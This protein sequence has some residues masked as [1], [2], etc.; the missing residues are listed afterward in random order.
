M[1][2]RK[3]IANGLRL[4]KPRSVSIKL[5]PEVYAWLADESD[6]M[7]C[8]LEVLVRGLIEDAYDSHKKPSG[9]DQK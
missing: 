1:L 2:D 4:D 3:L 6:S 8:A 9:G 5:R 7:K